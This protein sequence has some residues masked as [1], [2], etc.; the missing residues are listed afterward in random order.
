MRKRTKVLSLVAILAIAALL[1]ATLRKDQE[2]RYNGRPLSRWVEVYSDLSTTR[3]AAELVEA[4]QAIRAIGTNGLP[5][6]LKWIQKEPP[7]WQR[8]ARRYLP[9]RLSGNAAARFLIDGPDYDRASGAPVAFGFLGTNAAPAI[10]ELAALMTGSTNRT[11]VGWAIAALG[12]LGAPALPH[13]AAALSNTNQIGRDYIPN[14]ILMMAGVAGT[15]TCLS[16]LKAA[17]QDPDPFVSTSARHALHTLSPGLL[18]NP[19]SQ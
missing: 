2:P 9:G 14:Y 1:F 18:M 5:F 3:D 11:V 16:P 8:A 19:P 15:N 6:L 17:L 10:P 13:L 4:E 7:S 12:G